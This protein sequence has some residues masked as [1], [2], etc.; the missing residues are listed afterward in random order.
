MRTPKSPAWLAGITACAIL[1]LTACAHQPAREPAGKHTHT[2][3]YFGV[4]EQGE[5]LSFQ[6]V[7]AFGTTVGYMPNMVL[8]FINWRVPFNEAFAENVYKIGAAPL[9]QI[10]PVGAKVSAIADGQYDAYLRSYADAVRA[11]GHT[12][13]IG[14]AHEMNGYWYPWGFGH[15]KPATWIAAWKH[16]VTIFR[17]QGAKN[18]NWLW[19]VNILARVV[20]SPRDWWPGSAYVTWVGIDGY[21]Y[22]PTDTFNTVYEPTIQ[23]IREF[24]NKPILLAE[25]GIGELAGQADKIPGLFA[26]IE[27]DHLIGVVWMDQTTHNGLYHQDWRLEGHQK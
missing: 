21:Y 8:N 16:I 14:F 11:F 5:T 20:G 3:A 19:T 24:T 22:S 13:I 6:K 23:A 17:K 2:R 12:V 18:V 15:T 26:G 10:D 27:Q 4:Y 9:I 1:L 7:L 25:V